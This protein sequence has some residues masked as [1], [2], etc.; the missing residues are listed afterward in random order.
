LMDAGFLFDGHG[1][2]APVGSPGR[3]RRSSIGTALRWK[4]RSAR[5]ALRRVVIGDACSRPGHTRSSKLD[6]RPNQC[7]DG[8]PRTMP[9][10]ARF[11]ALAACSYINSL[12]N[13]LLCPFLTV[14]AARS[15]ENFLNDLEALR[16]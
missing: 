4:A 8:P 13:V 10:L 9:A 1:H 6:E 16:K 15:V 12:R 2:S 3:T 14:S 7:T 11:P 5:R